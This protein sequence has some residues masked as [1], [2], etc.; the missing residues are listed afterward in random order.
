M[1]NIC[2]ISEP[3]NPRDA[4]FGG[5]TNALKLHHK[6]KPDEQ[7]KY[8]DFTSL[9]PYVQKYCRYPIG[10]P[11]II[12]EN[13]DNINN[14]FGIIKCKILPPKGLYIPV[15]PLRINNKLVFTL[16]KTCAHTNTETCQHSDNE[17]ALIGTW[18]SLE[19]QQGLKQGYIVQQI[20]E[21]WHYSETSQYDQAKKSGGL[22]KEYVDLFLKY[23][24]EASGYPEDVTSDQQKDDYISNYFEKE[25][26]QLDKNNIKYNA[27]LRSVM[28]L[29]LNSFWGRFGMQ[30]NKTQ[31]KFISNLESWYN[32]LTDEL[33]RNQPI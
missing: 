27:G 7:I 19:V 10:H 22:F 31:V 29:M 5:R 14:Y 28:K 26:V 9:Y 6:C 3:I 24:Q 4:L 17:R 33:L 12:T 11:L 15:L 25:G 1:K 30:T 8:C 32:L 2:N 20:Y 16:C 21:V 13:F 18:V 23:K